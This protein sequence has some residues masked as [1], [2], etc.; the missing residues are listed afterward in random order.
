MPDAA[1]LS[2]RQRRPAAPNAPPRW[3]GW[4]RRGLLPLVLAGTAGAMGASLPEALLAF[5]HDAWSVDR[6]AP[7][8]INSIAQTP[9]GFLWIGSVEGLFRFDGVSFEAVDLDRPDAQ[10]LVVSSLRVARS[11]ELWVGLARSR[12]VAVFRDGRLVDAGMPNPSREVNDI[13]EDAEGGIWI[14]RGG[15]SDRT[16][17]RFHR[18]VWQELAD[19]SGLPAQPAWDLHAARDGT[20]WV[21]LSNTLAYRRPG[22]TRFTPTGPAITPRASLAEDGQGRL[23]ISDARG[24]RALDGPAGPDTVFAHPNPIGGTRLLFDRQG[25]LWTTTWNRGVVRIRAPGQPPAAPLRDGE[26]VASLDA[27]AGL[28][29]DLTRALFQD[30]EGNLWVGTELGLD[31]LRPASLVVEPAI[32]VNSPTSYRLAASRDG[33]VYVADATALYVIAPGQPPRRVLANDSAAE[34]L[35]A[36][37]DSGVW[38]FLADRVLQVT[39]GSV[40][41]L[42]KPAGTTAYGCAEDAQG[43]LWMPGLDQGLHWLQDGRWQRWVEASPSPSLPANAV[44]DGDGRVA[45]LFRGR[46]PQG[47]LPVRALQTAHARVGG[48]EG[49]LPT[50][51]GLLVSG[52][53]GLALAEA[54]SAS[55]PMLA[56]SHYPWAASINGL[57]QTRDGDTWA[58]GDA[59]ILRLR[60]ADLAAALERPGAN[61][62][63]RILHFPDGLNSFVQKAPGPQIVV[64]GDGRVW[65]LTRRNVMRVEPAAL[66]PNAL[67]AP[68]RVRSVQ[69]GERTFDAAPSIELPAGTTAMRVSFTALSLSVPAR[70]QFRHRLVGGDGRWSEPSPQRSALLTD[71]HPGRY[72]FEVR[73]SNNDGLWSDEA[74]TVTLV[75]PPT[76]TQSLGFKLAAGLLAALLLYALYLARVRQILVRMRERSEER[77][78]ERERIARDMHDTLLQSVQGLILRFQSVADRL[79]G[80]PP[81]RQA[82]NQALDRAEAVLVEGR[83]RLQGLRRIEAGDLEDAVRRLIAEQPFPAA[84][85]VR[86]ASHG[87][88]RSLRAEVFDE[89]LC[90]VGEALFNA[91]RHSGGSEIAVELR[92][93][94][95]WFEVQVRDNGVGVSEHKAELAGRS[96][97][98]G[99]LGMRERAERIGAQFRIDGHSSPGT[100]VSLRLKA[101]IAYGRDTA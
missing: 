66:V 18:G 72:R 54:P 15:R 80:D 89:I 84:T 43:R 31:Q 27:S 48:I 58:I 50:G 51:A 10:R 86:V 88:R 73:A 36:A 69:A 60:S 96:G 77:S 85:E 63:P 32:P 83:D 39:G 90:I 1:A 92:Y 14:A 30:R 5:K 76:F 17:A 67:Q 9:D 62:V 40:R 98:F 52:S 12:G 49:L 87:P 8:R 75:I 81:T 38:L 56:M 11:G 68:V 19:D 25:D 91:A 23:W 33:T 35:C 82:M 95:R 20:L 64:G 7:S 13:E 70:V 28:S 57:V 16:L 3:L 47:E 45:V 74:A 78:R 55:A 101:G 97:H 4:L 44:Q 41:R 26:R 42:P 29:S 59:G 71:L 34:A 99:M 53:R 79:Q 24:T 94:K 37:G 61:L 46:T 65:F 21:V 6:G 22:D 2:A 93:G 100:R